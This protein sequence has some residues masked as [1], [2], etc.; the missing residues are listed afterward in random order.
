M[1][2]RSGVQLS[3]T[4][5]QPGASSSINIRG[6]GSF[7][8]SNSPL[9]VIDGIPM[10]SGTINSM[11]SPAG[12]DIM[13]TINNSDI[14]SITVI[15]DAA[16]ASLYGSRAANGVILITTKKGKE[17]KATVSLK[18]DW[19]FSDFAMD[20][21]PVMNGADRREYIYN[22]LITRKIL[23]KATPEEAKSY[24]DD[25]ID[26]YAPIPWCGFINWDDIL[27]QKGKYQ[28]GRASCRERVASPL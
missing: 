1:L 5:G 7:N 21:R 27:F 15:K 24:A 10:Q 2:F 14:E 18:A 4:S 16:A 6:M 22:G 13:S 20:Y 17:G 28:I 8:A 11:S 12:L 9:Y 19:G 26:N 25:N 3:S 23:D